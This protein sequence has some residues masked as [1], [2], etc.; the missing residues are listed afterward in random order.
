MPTHCVIRKSR[1]SRFENFAWANSKEILFSNVV[2]QIFGYI[3]VGDKWMFVTLCW[4][5]F[6]GVADR[7]SILVTSFG[8]CCPMLMLKDRG[9]W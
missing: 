9:C 7:I 8:C 6:S 3:D 4:S 2:V 5:Q 1:K